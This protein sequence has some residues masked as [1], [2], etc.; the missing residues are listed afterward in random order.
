MLI[1]G[2]STYMRRSFVMN[3]FFMFQEN[4]H[5]FN[6]LFINGMEERIFCF[7][8]NRIHQF[9]SHSR[10][11]RLFYVKKYN[12]T[13][14]CSCL[15]NKCSLRKCKSQ[16]KHSLIDAQW[17]KKWKSN[18]RC[19]SW[20]WVVFLHSAQC[21]NQKIKVPQRKHTFFRFLPSQHL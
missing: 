10:L 14:C 4:F 15:G 2:S 11:W 6:K 21:S 13:N 18:L 12:R 20:T 5:S 7:N 3:C 16:Q 17:A 8:L 1:Y 19:K 9:L